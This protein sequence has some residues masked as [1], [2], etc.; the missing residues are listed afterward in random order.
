MLF[1]EKIALWVI[2]GALG[3]VL[4]ALLLAAIFVIVVS[5]SGFDPG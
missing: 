2:G 4:L 3:L 5:A 1:A